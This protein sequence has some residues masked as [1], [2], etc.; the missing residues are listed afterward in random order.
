MVREANLLH[1]GANNALTKNFF[2]VAPRTSQN[3][4]YCSKGCSLGLP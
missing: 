4:L 2:Q 3:V 1:E